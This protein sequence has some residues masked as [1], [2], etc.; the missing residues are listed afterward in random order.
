MIAFEVNDMTCGH[1][2][3]TITRALTATD[4]DARVQIDWPRTACRWSLS[5]PTPGTW[6]K[7]SRTPARHQCRSRRSQVKSRRSCAGPAV[8]TAGD[9]GDGGCVIGTG[10]G[11][12][13]K[14][15]HCIAAQMVA[16]MITA[17]L[18]S[19]FVTAAAY[20][21]MGR[22]RAEK[23]DRATFGRWRRVAT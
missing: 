1:C 9:S 18:L 8:D 11:T 12:S 5:L 17:P 23:A 3:S 21:L 19:M 22:P 6:P 14:V 20:L 10:T 16:G 4:K 13:S 2:V 15:M 7:P